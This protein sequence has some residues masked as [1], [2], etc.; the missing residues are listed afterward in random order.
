MPPNQKTPAFVVSIRG[1]NGHV[2]AYVFKRH[3]PDSN[4]VYWSRCDG[5]GPA[6]GSIEANPEDPVSL[7]AAHVLADAGAR[8]KRDHFTDTGKIA[9]QTQ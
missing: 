4:V 3:I 5:R 2:A 6:G 9:G 7:I 1:E 8:L